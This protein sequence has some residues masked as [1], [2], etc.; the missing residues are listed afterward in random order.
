[1]GDEEGRERG[2]VEVEEKSDDTKTEKSEEKDKKK[3]QRRGRDRIER[4]VDRDPVPEAEGR[5]ELMP[6]K[7]SSSEVLT[8]R[9]LFEFNIT[10]KAFRATMGNETT[11][12]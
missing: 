6:E 3:R 1:M 2:R 11:I 4:R 9:Y 5:R 10:S 12:E 8:F 7:E